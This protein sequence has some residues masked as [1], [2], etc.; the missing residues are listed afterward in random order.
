MVIIAKVSRGSKMDQIYIPKNRSEFDIGSYVVLKPLETEKVEKPYLYNIKDI[1]PI[2]L[3]ILNEIIRVIDKAIHNENIIITGSFLDE[4]F[5]FDDID[6]IIITEDKLSKD[7][8]E[9]NIEN[10]I[11]I[12]THIIMMNNKTLIEGLSLDPLYQM[13]LSKCIA[14]K[15]FIYNVEPKKDYKI[16]DLHLLKSELLIDN[17]NYLDG[18]EKYYL[19]RNMIAIYLYIKNKKID[20]EKTDKEI[21]KIFDIKDI[22]EIKYNMLNKEVFLGKYKKIYKDISCTIME[23]IKHGAK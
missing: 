9:K 15:R 17:F 3:D 18:N 12:K 4:G 6:V 19:I 22:K 14:K 13:M 5:N 21:K 1:E 11:R 7:N 23:N 16:L 2:K 20:K 8:I 10:K